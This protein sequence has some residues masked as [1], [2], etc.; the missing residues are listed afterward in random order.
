MNYFDYLK[1][2]FWV[3]NMA[4]ALTETSQWKSVGIPYTPQ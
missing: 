1:A 2:L 3:T 4:A